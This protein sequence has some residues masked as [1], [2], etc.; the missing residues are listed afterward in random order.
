[1][2]RLSYLRIARKNICNKG[3]INK[4]SS[5]NAMKN[6]ATLLWHDGID[7]DDI[8][9][10]RNMHCE[11]QNYN[12]ILVGEPEAVTFLMIPLLRW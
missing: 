1:L 11:T 10:G 8:R 5:D 2:L 4:R 9:G 6:L 3:S 12:T 7:K